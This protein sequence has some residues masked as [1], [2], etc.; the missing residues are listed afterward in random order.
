[1]TFW[2]N[3]ITIGILIGAPSAVLGYL[4][5]LQS[6]KVDK[7]SEESGI[8][9]GKAE[10]IAQSIDGLN[11][12]IVGLNSLVTA[13]QADKQ[14]DAADIKYLKDQVVVTT[15]QRDTLQ[16]ELNRMYRKYGEN[17]S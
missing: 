8:A 17:G 6:K 3:P 1:M 7:R 2:E 9:S 15:G 4:G 11:K 13:L 14:A 16:K 10:A 5:Y 12:V